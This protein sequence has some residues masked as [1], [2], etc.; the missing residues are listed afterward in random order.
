MLLLSELLRILIIVSSRSSPFSNAPD[1]DSMLPLIFSTALVIRH[2]LVPSSYLSMYLPT[3]LAV[4]HV[5][6][7]PTTALVKVR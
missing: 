1:Y 7:Y 5:W 4:S 6:V 2:P 3:N